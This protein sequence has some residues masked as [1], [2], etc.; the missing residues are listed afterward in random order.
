MDV[1][2]I[3]GKIMP[4][5]KSLTVSRE[6]IWSKNTGRAADGTMI[7]DI[8]G[9]KFKLQIVFALMSDADTVLLYGAI[10][11]AF[12]NVTF[13]NPETGQEDT[14]KMYANGPTSP[15]YS[16]VNGLPRYTGTAVNL[17]QQ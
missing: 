7:G 2:K 17:T 15:V 12:F 11:P 14:K 10:R 13:R 5:V 16:Y 3:D 6:P 8:V 9:Y 1:I 4:K